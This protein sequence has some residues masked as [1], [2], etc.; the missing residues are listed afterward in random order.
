MLYVA[1]PIYG[2]HWCTDHPV[3]VYKVMPIFQHVHSVSWSL[4]SVF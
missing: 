4:W 2:S 3:A 1:P